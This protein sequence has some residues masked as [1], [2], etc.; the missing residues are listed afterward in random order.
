MAGW[1]G[2]GMAVTMAMSFL[3]VIPIEPIYWLL[4]PPAG[5]LIGYYANQRSL[6]PRGAWRRIVANAV[7]AGL[8]TGLTLA[9]A[10]LLVKALFFFADNGFRDPAQG[11]PVTRPGSDGRPIGCE[12]GAECVMLRYLDAGRGAEFSAQGITDVASF[13]QAYWQQ[14]LS[15]AGLLLAL[16]VGSAA[17]GGGVYGLTRPT[18]A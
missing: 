11:G 12:P 5:L 3:L 8:V 1:V 4:A 2:V 14:Q 6:P 17:L 15:T 13:T 7:Y 10:L 18:V 16:S 9:L